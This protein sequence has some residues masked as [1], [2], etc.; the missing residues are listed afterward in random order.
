MQAADWLNE[1]CLDPKATR[2]QAMK[3]DCYSAQ[4]PGHLLQ[5]EASTK[6]ETRHNG[7]QTYTKYACRL[8]CKL[9]ASRC[10]RS[11]FRLHW[12]LP[13]SSISPDTC[14]PNRNVSPHITDTTHLVTSRL[15]QQPHCVITML[16]LQKF[17]ELTDRHA[18]HSLT[19]V[20]S[21]KDTSDRKSMNTSAD[22]CWNAAASSQLLPSSL[23]LSS[24]RRFQK[25]DSN[26]SW[27]KG[28]GPLSRA[29]LAPSACTAIAEFLFHL[30]HFCVIY[31]RAGPHAAKT[32]PFAAILPGG[33]PAL[34]IG[35][36]I[37]CMAAE[38][39]PRQPAIAGCLDYLV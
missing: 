1:L 9:F 37:P 16:H 38:T 3:F 7:C 34:V 4:E 33:R 14:P 5:H 36:T 27:G 8:I 23:S 12:Y 32:V 39:V 11:S 20:R 29:S 10:A 13:S 31:S 22:C 28:R 19:C 30:F 2:N 6:Q 18:V 24:L 21:L 15:T 35:Q 25:Y 26:L 17:H